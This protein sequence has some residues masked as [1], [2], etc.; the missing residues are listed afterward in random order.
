ML[1]LSKAIMTILAIWFAVLVCCSSGCAVV[2]RPGNP[3]TCQAVCANGGV[4]GCVWSSPI[5]DISCEAVCVNKQS[6]I[7]NDLYCRA[8]A[9][10]CEAVDACN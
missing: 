7:Q 9:T 2:V 4:L 8:N 1:K 5:N 3:A 6:I 10:T